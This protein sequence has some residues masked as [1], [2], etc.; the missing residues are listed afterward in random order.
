MICKYCNRR[1]VDDSIYCSYCGSQVRPNPAANAAKEVVF[2]DIN[3]R[4]VLINRYGVDMNDDGIISKKEI[5]TLSKIELRGGDK[6]ANLEGLE[7][8]VGL[9]E[10]IIKSC[11]SIKDIS[12]LAKLKNLE[13]VWICN[14]N[15]R[16]LSPLAEL[17][18][19]KVL[20]LRC[21][22]INDISPL[23]D[24]TNLTMLDLSDNNISDISPIAKM[25][26]LRDFAARDNK[27][28]DISV[29]ADLPAIADVDLSNNEI[30]D[31]SP[32]KYE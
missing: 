28:K 6:V 21:N 10:L 32:I 27:I 31:I 15:I 16:D 1:I 2:A 11:F 4:S 18:N 26:K 8:A 5:G 7:E 17:E 13:H 25:D 22:Q 14:T 19:L 24:L 20:E 12:P 3:L 30:E 23:E 9:K 29:I